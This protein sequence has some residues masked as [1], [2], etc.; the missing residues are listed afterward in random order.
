MNFE[1]IRGKYKSIDELAWIDIPPLAVITGKNGTG[2]TQL[3]ELIY[4]HFRKDKSKIGAAGQPFHN[5][6]TKIEGLDA[7]ESDVVFLPNIWRIGNLGAIDITT[8][9]GAIDHLYNWI[10]TRQA[11]SRGYQELADKIMQDIDKPNSDVTREDIVKNLPIDYVNYT[12][13]IS[14]NE[15]LNQIFQMYFVQSSQ[16][17]IDGKNSDEIIN[18]LGVPP[19][20]NL[21][22]ILKSFDF[23]YY[24]IEP[25]LLTGKYEL[26]LHKATDPNVQ[27]NF[28][29]L[30]SGE[31]RIITLF[32]W[33]YNTGHEN[34]LPKLML[35]DEPD[36]H[37]HPSLAK[38][39]M[40]VIE[41]ILVKQFE[42]RVILTTHSPST[43][44][45]VSSEFLFEMKHENPRI[46][47]LE[48]KD[49]GINLLT[50]GLIT[51]RP[52]N[53]FVLVE[54]KEDS[55]YYNEVFKI[56]KSKNLINIGINV[57]FIPSSNESAGLSGG[58]SVV[59]KW[60]EKFVAQGVDNVF[61][62][63]LDFD[64]GTSSQDV[65]STEPNIHYVNRYSLE[66]YLLDPIMIYA[67]RLHANNPI[68]I[69]GIDLQQKDE[70][71]IIELE[72]SQLQTISDKIFSDI[73]PM[74]GSLESEEEELTEIEFINGL[75][76][77]YPKWFLKRRGHDLQSKFRSKYLEGAR[78]DKLIEAMIRHD[79]VSLDLQ[80][81]IEQIQNQN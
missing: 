25:K 16:L 34:R 72:V 33:I 50:D 10:V 37:L 1:L 74:L 69:E 15:G 44:A 81:I 36:A 68:D 35:L 65:Q 9:N 61:Q 59:R 2:K 29:D 54:D 28:T 55:N 48:S 46:I 57:L 18:E 7:S 73:K 51:V 31:Q 30:S 75:K 64:N 19:W 11:N 6:S 43:V 47:A 62:G 12:M 71:R 13:K 80:N 20:E 21:N 26:K 60:V 41:N 27:I 23:P 49:Y 66:N 70:H 17:K 38:Q 5:V 56:L 45:F 42:V 24:I 58:C 39:F 22:R 3:L 78:N 63:L 4:F 53:K 32:I 76:L 77:N 40:D 8:H 52:N 67:A 14:A 79:H